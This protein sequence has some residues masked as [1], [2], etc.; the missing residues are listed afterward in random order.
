MYE[1]VPALDPAFPPLLDR[2]H[3]FCNFR[4]GRNLSMSY[5]RKADQSFYNTLFRELKFPPM[6]H[7]RA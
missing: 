3:P 1:V 6:Y 2:T 4:N 7:C 5:P